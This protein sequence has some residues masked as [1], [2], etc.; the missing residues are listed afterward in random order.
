MANKERKRSDNLIKQMLPTEVSRTPRPSFIIHYGD[1][2]MGAIASQITSLTIVYST[3]YSDA[4]QRKHQSFASLAFVWGIHRGPGT[5]SKCSIEPRKPHY[6]KWAWTQRPSLLTSLNLL[7]PHIPNGVGRNPLVCNAE[8]VGSYSELCY[9]RN[10]PTIS[11]ETWWSVDWSVTSVLNQRHS[12]EYGHHFGKLQ[13]W[14][15]ICFTETWF[16]IILR[17]NM[18]VVS[19]EM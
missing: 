5:P 13:F 17:D 9:E 16:Q 12:K 11:F 14:L 4:D 19:W 7:Q 6:G 1:V 10:I 18:F 2:I 3:V 8:V 15:G